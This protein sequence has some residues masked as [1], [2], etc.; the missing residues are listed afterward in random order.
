MD[1]VFEKDGENATGRYYIYTIIIIIIIITGTYGIERQRVHYEIF[2]RTTLCIRA[3]VISISII[4]RDGPPPHRI[5]YTHPAVDGTR[6]IEGLQFF[7]FFVFIILFL[8]HSASP[9]GRR[10][11]HKNSVWQGERD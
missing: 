2:L 8:M 6:F 3:T 5:T 10:A 4:L 9:P 7:F 11:T 1:R